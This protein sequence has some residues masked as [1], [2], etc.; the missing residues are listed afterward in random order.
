VV[1]VHY[2]FIEGHDAKK[3]P[4]LIVS[5]DE[6]RVNHGIYW[7]AMITTAKAG[8]RPEDVPV[9]DRKKAGLASDCVIRISRLTTLSDAQI[10]HSLG[11]LTAKDRRAV[12]ALLRKYLP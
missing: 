9:T 11:T 10:S 3:R 6:L 7:T 4:A 2:P 8:A 1:A 5:T 12:T